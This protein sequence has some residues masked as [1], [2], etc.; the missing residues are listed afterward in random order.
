MDGAIVPQTNER[1]VVRRPTTEE[2]AAMFKATPEQVRA[3]Y[4]ANAIQL[5]GMADKA[6][7]TGRKVNGYTEAQ[8]RQ[9]A[10]VA[11]ANATGGSR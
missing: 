7:L 2:V 5:K 4:A 1:T 8:L 11:E 9:L 6:A 3:Q 10:A